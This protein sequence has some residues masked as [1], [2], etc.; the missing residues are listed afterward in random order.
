M[1]MPLLSLIRVI[2]SALQKVKTLRQRQT[3][4][5]HQC[6]MIWLAQSPFQLLRKNECQARDA[7]PHISQVAPEAP[8]VPVFCDNY[9]LQV[10]SKL[11]KSAALDIHHAALALEYICLASLSN[12]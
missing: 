4:P 8:A 3:A 12:P 2:S 9:S 6:L 11:F 10:S 5:C 1:S 7:L